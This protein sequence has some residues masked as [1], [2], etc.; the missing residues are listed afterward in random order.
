MEDKQELKVPKN[1]I[2]E[3][4]TLEKQRDKLNEALLELERMIQTSKIF[5]SFKKKHNI[6][7]L[8]SFR[9]ANNF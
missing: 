8:E 3:M 7:N 6:T 9:N 4:E 1:I 2:S 5:D